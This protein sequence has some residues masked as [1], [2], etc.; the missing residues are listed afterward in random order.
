MKIVNKCISEI[1]DTLLGANDVGLWFLGQSGFCIRYR[2]HCIYIDVYLSEHLTAKYEHTEKPH[3]RMNPAPMRGHEIYGATLLIS[4]HKHSDHCD[5]V[6][7][8]EILSNSPDCRYII[9]HA[10]REHVL[11][12]GVSEERLIS[13]Y[14]GQ[15]L[16]L[17]GITVIP[18]PA[19]HEQFDY[20][21]GTGYPYMSY[22]IKLGDLAIYHSGDGI[23]Y[24]GLI[25]RLREYNADV[26]LLPINGRDAR[27]HALGTT[28]NMTIEEALCVAELADAS[29]LIP[30]H[31]EMFTFN[32]ADVNV[33][34]AHAD[35]CYPDR[36]V[37][38]MESGSGVI[39]RSKTSAAAAGA[40]EIEHRKI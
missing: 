6:S 40:R 18:M 24:A 7:V 5:P 33:F 16:E 36:A 20:V 11:G 13:A 12:F 17:G 2:E 30:H 22:I 32:S 21:D 1:C 23:P 15:P 35:E 31:H 25:E 4:S 34:S 27:R 14:A 29:L 9:P 39:L 8:P 37:C 38:V 3:I 26:L 10:L 19:K 28:G